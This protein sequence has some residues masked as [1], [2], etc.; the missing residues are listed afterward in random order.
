MLT[1]LRRPRRRPDPGDRN[2]LLRCRELLRE[3]R[4][5]LTRERARLER[6][7]RFAKLASELANSEQRAP[8][9]DH[10][11]GT[12]KRR[13]AMHARLSRRTPIMTGGY[14]IYPSSVS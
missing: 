6:N 11:I 14:D 10:H 2:R 13:R 8:P 3:F 5:V 12:R 4:A 7:Q 9:L 1:T